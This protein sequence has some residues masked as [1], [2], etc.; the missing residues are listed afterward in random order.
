MEPIYWKNAIEKL[1]KV[2]PILRKIIEANKNNILVSK[3]DA[4]S[5]LVK[6]IIGQQISVRAAESIHK[7]LLN[8]ID[9]SLKPD[10]I[11][12]A[13]PIYLKETGLSRQKVEYLRNIADYF[14][15]N[16]HATSD[17]FLSNA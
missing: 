9:H 7:R 16:P 17:E 12:M 8:K 2:D 13:N 14:V 4:F 1:S 10:S 15:S 5:T 3:R 6:S 11:L